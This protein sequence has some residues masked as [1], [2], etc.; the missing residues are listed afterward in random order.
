MFKLAERRA[1]IDGV[2][3]GEDGVWLG[4]APLV[5]RRGAGSYQV[6][7][8]DEIEALVAA[9]YAVPPDAAG[10]I[11]GLHLVAK[12]LS[13]GNLPLAMIAAVRLRMGEIAE[14]RIERLARA[15]SLLKANFNPDEPRDD[16]GRWI[17][18]TGGNFIFI[19][20]DPHEG[21]EGSTGSGS[22]NPVPTNA[23][24]KGP[25]VPRAWEHYPNADFRNRLAIAEQSAGHKNFG[26]GEANNI[27]DPK[28]IAL[29]RYQMTP[30]GLEAAGMMDHAGNWTGKYGIHSPAEFLADP[31][32]QEKALTDYIDD[33]IRLLRTKSAFAHIGETIDGLKARFPV[34]R[35]GIIAA[36]HREGARA[37][38][39]YLNRIKANGFSSRGLLLSRQERAIETPSAHVFCRAL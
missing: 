7:A 20:D 2:Y 22:R 9:A 39:S 36:A 11:A 34:T 5:G 35:A 16:H 18:S 1:A 29:G 6:R 32:A 8:G 31:D 15:D 26:Y 12:Y 14:D 4:P 10:C 33:N 28:L 17:E 21:D 23:G 13:E 25:A 38:A 19:F 37:T 3:C 27:N 30:V 24:G